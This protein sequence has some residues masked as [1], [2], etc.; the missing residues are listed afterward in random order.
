MDKKLG[1]PS[2]IATGMG[3]I[4]AT[5]CLLSLGQGAGAIGVSFIAAMVIACLINI[6]TALSTAELNALMPSLTGG[7]A[8]YTLTCMGPFVSLVV[9]VGGYLVCN[10]LT[11]SVE[12]AMFGASVNAVFN[13]G[14]PSNVF[15]VILVM[16]LMIVNLN[17]VDMFAKIQ[18]IVAYG[19][20]ASLVIMG[21]ISIL[22]LGT[23]ETVSQPLT[24]TTDISDIFSMVG[25]AFFLFLGAEFIIPIAGNVKNSQRNVPLGM[26]LSLLIVLCM[27]I[28]VVLGMHNYVLWDDLAKSTSPHILYGFSLFGRIGSVWMILASIFAVVSTVNS[29]MSSL[30]YICAGMSKI[31]LLPQFFC[32][33]NKKGVPYIGV[34]LV[35]SIIIIINLTGLS[36]AEQLSFFILTGCVFWMCAYI[37]SNL[38]VIILRKRL[39]NAPRTFKVPFGLVIPICGIIGNIIMIWNIDGDPDVKKQFTVFVCLFLLC[40]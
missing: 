30:P 25:L 17:G 24:L 38:N 32:R 8:Q 39:K 35:S 16:F 5:S 27:Q 34:L 37:I 36:S 19:L 26:L 10:A 11:G 28:I 9:M 18:N 20:I 15:C 23:G 33:K 1:L 22:G 12:C 6:C 2:V 7:L 29:V 40:L 3:L 31:G 4:V 21:I 14:I 13:T